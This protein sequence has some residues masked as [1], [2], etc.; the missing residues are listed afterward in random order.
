MECTGFISLGKGFSWK[1]LWTP[2]RNFRLH[3]SVKSLDRLGDNRVPKNHSVLWSWLIHYELLTFSEK[4]RKSG[5]LQS[6][7]IKEF[8]SQVTVTDNA[9]AF[10]HLWNREEM[11]LKVWYPADPRSLHSL[12]E[13]KETC[14]DWLVERNKLR[15]QSPLLWDILQSLKASVFT[16]SRAN[17]I[18]SGVRVWLRV[19]VG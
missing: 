14:P 15:K 18:S 10:A 7:A 9:S 1:V 3:K 5:N 17:F 16:P 12:A 13:C 2:S 4:L 8:G 11:L 6:A 19:L